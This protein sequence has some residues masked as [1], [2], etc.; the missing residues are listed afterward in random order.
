MIS[1]LKKGIRVMKDPLIFISIQRL[2]VPDN[3]LC[4]TERKGEKRE[5]G[6]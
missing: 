1:L 4:K 2:L 3:H 6:S 5:V